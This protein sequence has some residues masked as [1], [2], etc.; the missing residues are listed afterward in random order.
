MELNKLSL[1]F[2]RALEDARH[3]A[4]RRGEAF[5]SP[6]HLLHVMLENNGALAAIAE[7]QSLNR[8]RVLDVLAKNEEHATRL[9]PGKRPI[10]G[11]ALRDLIELSFNLADRRGSTLVE[12]F[13]LLAAALEGGEER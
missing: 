5:I 1:E 2:D 10:A 7:K 8:T 12:P 4:E 6:L 3:F 13:D 11:K 9:E